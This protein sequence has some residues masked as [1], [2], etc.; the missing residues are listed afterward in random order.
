MNNMLKFEAVLNFFDDLIKD[1]LIFGAIVVALMVFIFYEYKDC[2][3]TID[4][5]W[6]AIYI[7]IAIFVAKYFI[8]MLLYIV[9][10][11]LNKYITIQDVN[12]H[13]AVM[14]FIG[15]SGSMSSSKSRE[16]YWDLILYEDDPGNTIITLH[17]F[18]DKDTDAELQIKLT[19]GELRDLVELISTNIVEPQIAKH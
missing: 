8:R 19:P 4:V 17:K 15:E 9:D 6:M 16:G 3:I 2:I 14:E 7:Y 1:L 11:K 10:Y 18:N 13:K 5:V 12:Y